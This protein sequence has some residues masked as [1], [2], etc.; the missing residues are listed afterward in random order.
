VADAEALQLKEGIHKKIDVK[1]IFRS[2]YLVRRGD[3]K[4]DTGAFIISNHTLH[5]IELAFIYKH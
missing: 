2:T 3:Q 5:R 4:M 1:F